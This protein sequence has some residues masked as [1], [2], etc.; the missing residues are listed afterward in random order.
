MPKLLLGAIGDP[1]V[2]LPPGPTTSAASGH[3]RDILLIFGVAVI[4]GLALFLYVYVTRRGRRGLTDSGSRVIYRAEKRG[5]RH[6][7][8]GKQK[9]RKKRRRREDFAHRNP[10][11]GETGGLPPLRTDEP[12]EPIL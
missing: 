4:L 7:D 2:N 6:Q 9:M 10:T 11:L 1:P 8:P 3:L 12:A 5:A